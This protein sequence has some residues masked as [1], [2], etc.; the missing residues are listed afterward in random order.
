MS[1]V[2]PVANPT[3]WRTI[4]TASAD[5]GRTASV[6]RWPLADRSESEPLPN[7][8]AYA[9]QPT[10]IAT[11]RAVPMGTGT[12]RA[13]PAVHGDTTVVV[14]RGDD[15]LPDTPPTNDDRS[16]G[17]PSKKLSSSV[18]RVGDRF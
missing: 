8:L 5:A 15:R 2:T 14:K 13:A 1:R 6:A 4:A 10:P 11:A 9:S 3:P 17:M 12:P 16:S 18:V 7:A